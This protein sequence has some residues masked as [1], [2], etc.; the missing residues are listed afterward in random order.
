MNKTLLALVLA[1]LVIAGCDQKATP[2]TAPQEQTDNTVVTEAQVPGEQVLSA[3]MAHNARNSLDW[4]GTYRGI[5]PCA[6]CEGIETTLEINLDGTFVLTET[7][8]GKEKGQFSHQGK[9]NWNTAGNTIAVPNDNEDVAQYFVAENQLF[10]LDRDGQRI[11]GDLADK[12][13]LKKQ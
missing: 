11:T 9:F 13:V 6:D 2:D 4:N 3:D 5:L 7:Y 12:Y 10:R 1:G 8:L